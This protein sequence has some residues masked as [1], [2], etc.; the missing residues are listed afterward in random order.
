M[1]QSLLSRHKAVRSGFAESSIRLLLMTIAFASALSPL[2]TGAAER[3]AGQWQE[4][5]EIVWDAGAAKL[6]RRSFR[7]WDAYPELGLE[8]QWSPEVES[9]TGA[10]AVNGS[11]ELIWYRRDGSP[12]DYGARYSTYKGTLENGRP[13]GWGK[14]SVRSGFTYEGAWKDG[15][16]DGDGAI[17]YG[18]G[19]RYRGRF[20]AG[21]P[22]RSGTFIAANGQVIEG[23]RV[24]ALVA[25]AS[26]RM[27]F[28]LSTLSP[29]SSNGP[30]CAAGGRAKHRPHHHESLYRPSEEY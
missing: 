14:L 8:F 20:I 27:P 17:E 25:K 24:A 29:K 9:G 6:V 4:K 2:A 23:S 19:D 5:T 7:I 28:G 22:D 3:V 16:M 15:R 30:G 11:G 12:Y 1:L 26:A 18:T 21:K 13:D 10:G